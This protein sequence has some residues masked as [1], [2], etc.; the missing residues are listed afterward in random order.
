M[1]SKLTKVKNT[2]NVVFQGHKKGAIVNVERPDVYL[3]AGW[4]LANAKDVAKKIE[5]KA[6][7]KLI[8]FKK[9]DLIA[10]AE[11]AGVAEKD[12]EGKNKAQLVALIEEANKPQDVVNTGD[13]E[14]D[15]LDVND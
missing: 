7:K 6:E 12:I 9:D 5:V 8:D 14:D 4:K 2:T 13:G 1:V 15:D 11:E 3:R 10:M